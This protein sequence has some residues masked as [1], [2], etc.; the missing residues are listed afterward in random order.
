[1]FRDG[2]T[3]GTRVAVEI[4]SVPLMNGERVVGVY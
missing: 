4:S 2:P 3:A 1:L